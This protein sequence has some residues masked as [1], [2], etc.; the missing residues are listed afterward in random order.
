MEAEQTPATKVTWN[1]VLATVYLIL[2]FFVTQIIGGV[3][4][5]VYAQLRYHDATRIADLISNSPGIQFSYILLVEAMS[6]GAIFLFV[7]HFKTKLSHIGLRRPKFS[8]IG[9]AVLTLPIYYIIFLVAAY[10]GKRVF[11]GLNVD[12][13]QDIGFNGVS[14]PVALTLTFISLVV[15]PPIAEEI[16]VRGFLYTS[17][18][19]VTPYLVSALLSSALFGA[20]HLNGASSGGPLWIAFIDTFIL[21]FCLA[22]LREKTGGLWSSM[23]LHSLKN[24]VAFYLLF[25]R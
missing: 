7:R 22:T 14:G 25:I 3:L 12:Q 11:P 17:L 9:W 16:M 10:V 21:G 24:S 4:I 18:R 23:L 15:L 5:S 13:Q 1:P 6:V 2:V 20:A 8:D 19:K